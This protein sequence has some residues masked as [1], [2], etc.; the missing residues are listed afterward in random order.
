MGTSVTTGPKTAMAANPNKLKLSQ[1]RTMNKCRNSGIVNDLGGSHE[2]IIEQIEEEKKPK[3]KQNS[4]YQY[5]KFEETK[6]LKIF[7]DSIKRSRRNS[8]NNAY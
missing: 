2:V 5:L 8:L 6:C 3:K 1:I 4:R 7:Q